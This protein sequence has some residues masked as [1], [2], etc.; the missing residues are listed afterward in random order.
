[1]GTTDSRDPPA[2]FGIGAA[3]AARDCIVSGGKGVDRDGKGGDAG[4]DRREER[5]SSGTGVVG[6]SRG[7]DDG[8]MVGGSKGGGDRRVG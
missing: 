3:A 5:G 1:V 8:A 4:V 7:I 2:N 6:V